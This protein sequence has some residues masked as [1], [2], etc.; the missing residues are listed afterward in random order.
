MKIENILRSLFRHRLNSTIIIVSLAIGIAI[1]NLIF[2][3]V[4]RE[5]D[6]DGFQKNKNRIYALEADNPFRKG[7]RVPYVLPGAAEYMKNNFAEVKDFCRILYEHPKKLIINNQ[8][9]FDH[10]RVIAASSNFFNFFSYKLVL[11]KPQNVL[12]TNQDIVISQK[13]AHKYFGTANPIGQKITLVDLKGRQ[14]KMVVSGVFRKPLESSSLKF[15]MVIRA[16]N[17]IGSQC[18]LLLAKNTKVKQLEKKFFRYRASIPIISEGKTCSYYLE[19]LKSTYFGT[20]KGQY[21][22]DK[23]DLTLALVIG[24]MILGIAFFNYLGLTNNRLIEKTMEYAIRCVNGSSIADL[25]TRFMVES[26]ILVGTAFALSL[27]LIGWAIP[28]FNQ[29]TSSNISTAYIFETRR[30]VLLLGIPALI[31][32]VTYIFALVKIKKI[33]VIEGLKPV[34]SQLTG[35]INFPVFNIVQLAVSVVLIIASFV[36]LKQIHYII[37]KD[38]GL[39]KQVLEVRIPVQHKN[40]QSVFKAELEKQPSVEV[41]S[42]AASSP[43]TP[44]HWEILLRYDDHG[45]NKQYISNFFYGDQ[46]YVNA[47]GIKIIKGDNFSKNAESNKNKCLINES[48]A[49]LFT[50]RQLIGH[51][52]PGENLTIIGI[53]K[54]FNYSSAKKFIRPSYIWY[55][56]NGNFL[57]VKPEKGQMAHVR[58]IISKIWDKLIPDYPVN[59]VSIGDRYEWLNRENKNYANLIGACSLISVFLSM[60]GLFA[61]AFHSSRLRTK[62]IGIRKINGATVSEIMQLLTKDF[63]KWVVIAFIIA[64]PIAYYAMHRWLQNFAYKTSLNW[65][66]FALAGI[67]MLLI[68]LLTVSWQTFTAARKNP[69]ESLRYE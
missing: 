8:N 35:K 68:T 65:W 7:E 40:I 12:K 60:I 21:G 29:L 15:D 23:S 52:L 46:N 58:E 18:Y 42:M 59:I 26:F 34:N 6:V 48:L 37:N 56:K 49:K 22:R 28:V 17:N 66:I 39:N 67:I 61:I 4:I 54:D 5:Y 45:K 25:V 69:V 30:I 9:Y 64:I 1:M 11:N 43:V 33:K 36:I 13:L 19:D 32:L 31:L 62:E 38:I 41:V 14:Q 63:V 2:I 10:P 47:L 55:R 24:F 3:F 44:P 20:N 27:I 57:I 16:N 51:K 53:V 50:G